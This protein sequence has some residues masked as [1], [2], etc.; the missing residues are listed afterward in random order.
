M[1]F[2]LLLILLLSFFLRTN[3]SAAAIPQEE[4]GRRLIHEILHGDSA[5]ISMHFEDSVKTSLTKETLTAIQGQISWL[6]KMIGDTVEQLMSGIHNDTIHHETTFFREYRLANESNKRYPLI[7]IHI[8][9]A[10]S[11]TD[12]AAGAFVKSFLENSEKRIDGDQTWNVDGKNIDVNSI[13]LVEFKEGSMMAI[14]VYDDDTAQL[15][16]ARARVRGVPIIRKAIAEGVLTKAKAELQGK[17]LI[18]NIGVAFIRKDPHY[19]YTQYK[20]GIASKDYAET[21][22]SAKTSPVKPRKTGKK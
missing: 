17:T 21:T 13:V 1:K 3:A 6:S 9:F 14:K 5:S 15:D 19:G 8:W 16:T 18:E 11:T 10:D 12:K 22:P 2:K 4:A 7:V 20:Y